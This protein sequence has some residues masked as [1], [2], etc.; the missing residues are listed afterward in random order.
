LTQEY[1]IEQL[2]ALPLLVEVMI[3]LLRIVALVC[4]LTPVYER[5]SHPKIQFLKNSGEQELNI[6]ELIRA[7]F[8]MTPVQNFVLVKRYYC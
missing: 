5:E 3:Q 2:T 6:V 7:E 8:E 4:E 1:G